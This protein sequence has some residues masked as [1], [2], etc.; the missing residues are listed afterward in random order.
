MRGRLICAAVLTMAAIPASAAVTVVGTT[1]ARMCYE[2]AES[3]LYNAGAT[4]YCDKALSE[5]A[6]TNYETVAT[7][8]NR[9]I[10]KLKGGVTQAAISDFDAAIARDPNQAE[11]YLNKGVALSKNDGWAQAL[12]MFSLAIE[13]NTNKPAVAYFSRGVAHEMTGDVQSAYYDYKQASTIDPQ[14]KRPQAELTRFT[15]V[16]K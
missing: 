14:W 13:K 11:A 7:F 5:E 6:L 10:L 4:A 15:V 16:R 3:G 12:P 1:S 9:G 8:V 2:A